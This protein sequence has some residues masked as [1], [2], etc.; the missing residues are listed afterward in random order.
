MEEYQSLLRSLQDET[1][2]LARA[3][4]LLT[5]ELQKITGS[6]RHIKKGHVIPFPKNPS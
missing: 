3:T 1:I 2:A 4:P 5:V 6:T